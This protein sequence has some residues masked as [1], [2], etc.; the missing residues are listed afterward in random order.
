M[1]KGKNKR[2]TTETDTSNPMMKDGVPPV[3]QGPAAVGSDGVNINDYSYCM[4]FGCDPKTNLPTSP[5]KF[6]ALKKLCRKGLDLYAY[7]SFCKSKII[8]LIRIPLGKMRKYAEEKA[9]SML[10]NP[11][12]LKEMAEAGDAERNVGPI[13]LE[14]GGADNYEPYEYIYAPYRDECEAI[15]EH[16]DG[17]EH[18]FTELT[19]NQLCK[20]MI[21]E[22]PDDGSEPFKIRRYLKTGDIKAFFP[23]HAPQPVLGHM[24]SKWLATGRFATTSERSWLSSSSSSPTTASTSFGPRCLVFPSRSP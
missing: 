7:Q 14:Q 15:Y 2:K 6:N 9:Q 12:K 10:L 8:V 4:V 3:P 19:R 11:E 24:E 13:M 18:P 17:E 21:E 16:G 23:L 5:T 22:R 20:M 1:G